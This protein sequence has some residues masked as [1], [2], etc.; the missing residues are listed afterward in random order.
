MRNAIG[1]YAIIPSVI[2]STELIDSFS[3]V[4]TYDAANSSSPSTLP[5][6]QMIFSFKFESTDDED[7]EVDITTKGKTSGVNDDKSYEPSKISLGSVETSSLALDSYLYPYGPSG[8]GILTSSNSIDS[9]IIFPT[10]QG[11]SD[12]SYIDYTN[13]NFSTS[14]SATE[15]PEIPLTAAESFGDFEYQKGYEAGV[16]AEFYGKSGFYDGFNQGEADGYN[17]GYRNGFRAAQTGS[18]ADAFHEAYLEG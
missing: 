7:L 8:R 11:T 12:Y 10:S 9:P 13:T 6:H 18:L 17:T 16:E 5:W 3:S 1:I 14:A 2:A 15:T 4:N